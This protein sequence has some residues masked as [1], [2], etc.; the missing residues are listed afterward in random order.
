MKKR[1]ILFI[2]IGLVLFLASCNKED[3]PGY[4]Y[5]I[6]TLTDDGWEVSSSNESG[7][8]SAQLTE[9]VNYLESRYVHNIHSIVIV[10]NDKLVFEKYFEGYL[11]SNN[12][13]GSNGDFIQY[14]RETDHF[15]ASVSKTVTSVIFGAAIR[16]GFIENVDTLLIDVLPEYGQVL[17][18]EK[19]DI[20]LKHLLCMSSGLHW[21]EWSIPY[22]DPANDVAAL[23]NEDD[24]I[25][26]ILSKHMTNSPGDEFH[27]NSGGTNVL[28]AVI[29]KETGMSL[30]D[31]GN[32]YLFDPLNMQGGLWET[33]A[34]GY[35]FAS[36]GVYLRPRELTKIGYLFLNEGSWDNTQIITEEWI[37]ESTSAHIQTD[38]LIPQSDS[39]GYQWWIMDFFA[40]NQT[41]ECFFAAG[42][43][44][45]YMFIFPDQE[46][47]ITINSGNYTGAMNMSIF[48]FVE[49]HILP[50]LQ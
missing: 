30:L 21:D 37:S 11:Y 38:N 36:G 4:T 48:N 5:E 41:Y 39:Y 9:M 44:D 2:I 10:K 45:Q 25:E 26:Y 1:G 34:G 23:F 27:Y 33:M 28:G 3:E 18:G 16:A 32:E 19:A 29:E 46:M 15:L 47:I 50:G 14:D 42:W 43:G 7:L 13:P 20:T 24:P 40:N 12:P 17:I 8:D 6:P 35:Y 31:F 22:N 49:N